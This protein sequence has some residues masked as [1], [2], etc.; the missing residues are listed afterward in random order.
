[1]TELHH[2]LALQLPL[3]PKDGKLGASDKNK[4]KKERRKERK[5]GKKTPTPK[6]SPQASPQQRAQKPSLPGDA[7][8]EQALAKL[9][10]D[11]D[12]AS[13]RK[14]CGETERRFYARLLGDGPL[15]PP[16][17]QG[18]VPRCLR[19]LDDAVEL[20]DTTEGMLQAC[21]MDIKLGWR[22]NPRK[23]E[24][25]RAKQEARIA[26]TTQKSLGVRLIHAKTEGMNVTREQGKAADEAQL[27]EW[28]LAF[29]PKA[30]VPQFLAQTEAIAQALREAAAG[31]SPLRFSSASVLYCYD[32]ASNEAVAKLIDFAGVLEDAEPDGCAEG[33]E[34]LAAVF[35]SP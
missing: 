34:W 11:E 28:V 25:K 35:R 14:P 29:A 7:V 31:D 24:A 19:V 33:L 26:E 8:L 15:L 20:E 22:V 30:V 13:F 9:S 18:V 16:L 21:T 4:A 3:A 2:N 17:L 6:A 23:D 27:K 5:S 32:A 1:M 10:M 12:A